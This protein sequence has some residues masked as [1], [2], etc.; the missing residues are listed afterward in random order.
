M[1]EPRSLDQPAE[2]VFANQGQSLKE[3]C[4]G[5]GM[6]RVKHSISPALWSSHGFA[7]VY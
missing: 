2:A 3:S 6:S 7:A 5:G 1:E 4:D